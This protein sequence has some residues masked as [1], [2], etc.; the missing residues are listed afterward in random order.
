M[1]LSVPGNYVIT[2][3]TPGTCS[4]QSTFS[5]SITSTIGTAFTFDS[6]YCEGQ[7]NPFPVFLPG[8][9]PGIFSV[10]PAGLVFAN[11]STGIIDLSTSVPGTYLITNFI[12]ASGACDSSSTQVTVTI[13]PRAIVT[14]GPDVQQCGSSPI[15][16]NGTVS[17]GASS[18]IWTT[19]GSGIFD[20]PTT[21]NPL[22]YP[23]AADML[24]GSVNLLIESDDPDWN[25]PCSSVFDVVQLF[26]A[27][28]V[29][30][31][32][33]N[34]LVI[35]NNNLSVNLNG[36]IQGASG[37]GFWSSSGSGMFLPNDSTLNA[38]Y[39]LSAGDSISG[40]IM[41]T[42]QSSNNGFC[43]ISYDTISIQVS[44][45]ATAN[46]GVDIQ[47]Y[48]TAVTVPLNGNINGGSGS[49]LWS[50]NGTGYFS[51]GDSLLN[52]AY[53]FSNSDIQ[54]GYVEIILMPTGGCSNI[55]DTLLIT[56]LQNPIVVNAGNYPD[57]CANN[58]VQL[59][60]MVSNA[61]GGLWETTGDGNFIP[62]DT[63]LNA[64][65]IPGMLDAG[66]GQVIL[67]LTSTGNGNFP[68][69]IDTISI[70]INSIPTSGFS[71][72]NLCDFTVAFTDIS[73][74]STG[75][76]NSWSWDFG[77]GNLNTSQ[78]PV[79]T[80]PTNGIYPVELIVTNQNGCVDSIII[81]IQVDSIP[82]ANFSFTSACFGESIIFTDLSESGTTPITGWNWDFGDGNFSTDQNPVH[83]YLQHGN[84]NVTLQLTNVNGCSA[85]FTTSVEV[86]EKPSA[87]FGS[88]GS[89]T[90]EI[91]FVDGSTL[92]NGTIV[93]WLWNFGD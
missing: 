24:S 72:I 74:D 2:Y 37:T 31:L 65:Y 30:T 10:T 89:C 80:F 62:S 60:G 82:V 93:T 75:I 19:S 27:D 77:N 51:P 21:I 87:L 52:T 88:T 15:R 25:G 55:P 73:F 84:Y 42:L 47:V 64:Q 86:F 92:F 81:S 28:T 35:C 44:S 79:Y 41:L 1:S 45:E 13:N 7:S 18:V 14:A 8:S 12:G 26:L 11:A 76:I 50:T 17:G 83:Y 33:G 16:L 56:I 71:Y 59:N 5:L 46:A 78:N 40:S 63:T 9:G 85:E 61:T 29:L 38:T 57:V 32:A 3:T 54:N 39:I 91:T 66:A 58:P 69:V 49:G 22:Y 53:Y 70:N 68:E 36:I 48:S 20:F 6:Q 43:P 34:D 90:S 67:T 23:S 4:N